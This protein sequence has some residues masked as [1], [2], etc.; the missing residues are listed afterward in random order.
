MPSFK[1]VEIDVTPAP[2]EGVLDLQSLVGALAIE[3]AGA[4]MKAGK[5]IVNG[6]I[7]SILPRFTFEEIQKKTKFC[8]EKVAGSF[9]LSSGDVNEDGKGKLDAN[10]AA[11]SQLKWYEQY[12]ET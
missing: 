11:N 2:N 3:K 1:G 12:L 9:Y 7:P 8:E 5:I 4:Q 10:V 6:H